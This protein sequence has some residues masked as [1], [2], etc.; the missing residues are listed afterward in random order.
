[1]V[2]PTLASPVTALLPAH[3]QFIFYAPSYAEMPNG[4]QGSVLVVADG[5][6]VGV[7]NNVN[8]DVQFDGSAA[9]NMPVAQ[10]ETPA[11][12][13]CTI[14]NTGNWVLNVDLG[15]PQSLPVVVTVGDDLYDAVTDND[16]EATIDDGTAGTSNAD[17]VLFLDV[18]NNGQ[19]DNVDVLLATATCPARQVSVS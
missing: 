14:S 4:F 18:N 11:S 13:A 6:V 2:A 19:V 7:S 8:Y 1:L 10:E 9:Y 3:G 16:G 17:A 15:V 12:L 5:D